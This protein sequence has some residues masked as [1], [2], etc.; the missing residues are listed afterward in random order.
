MTLLPII[1][2]CLLAQAGVAADSPPSFTRDAKSLLAQY[3]GR[4]HNKKKQ[5]GGVDLVTFPDDIAALAKRNLWK[6][7]H[8]RVV[9]GEMPPED[10]KQLTPADKIKLAKWLAQA[11]EYL[12][13][14]PAHR[15]PGPSLFRRLTLAE[16]GRTISDLFNIYL[17]PRNDL[18]FPAEEVGDG[19]FDNLAASLQISPTLMEKFFAAADKITDTIF[20]NEGARNRLLNPKP[21][22]KL[23]ERDAAKQILTNLAR[24]A[25][26]RPAADA[27]VE[28]LLAFY[29]KTVAKGGSF[30]DGIRACLKPVLVS[31]RFL[32]RVEEDRTGKAPGVLV[33]DYELATRLSYFLWGTMPD[34]ELFRAAEQKKLSDPAGLEKEISRM[35]K[36]DRARTFTETL[37]NNWLM[38]KTF[39]RARPTTE[40]FPTFHDELKR[41]MVQE[42]KMMVDYLRT[43]DRPILDLLDADYTFVNEALA[44]HYGIAGVTGNQMRKVDLRPEHHRGGLLGMGGIL[45]MTSHTFRTSPTQRGKYI[46]EVVFGTPPPPPPANVGQLKGDDPKKKQPLTFREQLDQHATQASCAGCHKKIDPLGF[47]LDNFNAIGEWRVGSTAVPLDVSGVL[48]SGEKVDG[49]ASLKAILLTRK[50]EFAQNVIAKVLE[51]AL[52]R[53]LDGQDECTVR[54]VHA[55]MKK[56]DYRFTVMVSEIVKSVPFRQRRAKT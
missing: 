29:D 2:N 22:P 4:C 12:D 53:E 54:E 32:F 38:M 3:C 14:D 55:A 10:A 19:R 49:F 46:L 16:Y 42:V 41:P 43:S 28:R 5:E 35:L 17:D 47:A 50:D 48:P 6:H 44:K 39:P 33:D 36:H 11:A 51:Y 26:R 13:C 37:A 56:A 34:E 7:A 8:A 45:A 1:L 52:G 9:A 15:D 24:R 20:V 21:G 18:G 31:P 30:E 40:F 23:T 27:D 25:Y